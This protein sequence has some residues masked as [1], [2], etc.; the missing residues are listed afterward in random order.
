MPP[1]WLNGKINTM[2]VTMDS[3]GRL[4]IPKKLREEAELEPD[5]P[6]EIRCHNGV[7]EIAPKT[8]EV[9]LVKKGPFLVARPKHPVPPMTNAMVNRVIAK[10]RRERGR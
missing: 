6:L 10:I 8:L 7:I 9:T 3:A 1:A 5:T 2:T 4:V